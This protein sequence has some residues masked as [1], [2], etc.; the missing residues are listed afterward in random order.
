MSGYFALLFSFPLRSISRPNAVTVPAMNTLSNPN[1]GGI[2][3]TASSSSTPHAGS[4][5]VSPVA[6]PVVSVIGVANAEVNEISPATAGLLVDTLSASFGGAHRTA[7]AVGIGLRG[8]FIPASDAPAFCKAQVFAGP[9]TRVT[10]RFSNGSGGRN[11]DDR[12]PDV[13]GLSVKFHLGDDYNTTGEGGDLDMIGV[14]MSSFFVKTPEAFLEFLRLTVPRPDTGRVDPVAFKEWFDTHPHAWAVYDAVHKFG[15]DR[16]FSALQY[17]SLHAFRYTNADGKV[18]VARF[19]WVPEQPAGRYRFGTD[20]TDWKTD[21]LRREIVA[22]VRD[23]NGPCYTL[24][25]QLQGPNDPDDDS[26]VAWTSTMFRTLGRLNLSALV[27]DQYWDCEALR[28][29]PG[30]LIDGI[31][32]SPDPVLHARHNTYDTS[33][34][35]RTAAYP[36]PV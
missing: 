2:S 27:A 17:N 16:S 20:T 30:R 24:V 15:P 28:F 25:A 22:R 10:A 5:T 1:D 23:G 8:M 35:R 11:V 21:Y 33:A 14:S 3:P 31:E 34:T 7:H 4:P 19:G 12:D 18:S 9:P 26:S 36:P 29:N 13:R 32:M 6:S